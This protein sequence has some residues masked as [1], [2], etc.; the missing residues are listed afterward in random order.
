MQDAYNIEDLRRLARHRLP[1]GLFEFVDRGTED[2]VA[3]ANNRAAFERIKFAPHVLVDVS[4]RSQ[5]VELFGQ[6]YEMPLV[7]APT[8]SAGLMWHEGEIALA[9]AAAAAGIPCA[10]ATGS[11]TAME[12]VAEQGGAVWFQMAPW[13]DR[14]ITHKLVERAENAGYQALIVTVDGPVAANREYNL[15]N[16]Y[17]TPFSFTRRNTLDVLMH[18]RW[19][20]TV[21]GRYVATTGMPRYENYPSEV[22]QRITAQ[23]M[24]KARMV[25]DNAT[26]EDMR[27]LREKWRRPLIVKGITRAEDARTAVDYGA[28]GIIVSNH[29]G[30]VLDGV[31]APIAVLPEI[32]AAVGHRTTVMVDS[33]FRRGSDVVKAL[34]LGA[35]AVLIG[36]PTLYGT[37]VGG[38]AGAA[39]ALA[40]FRQEI[41]RVMAL[42]GAT[43]VSQLDQAFLRP[44]PGPHRFPGTYSPT[45]GERIEIESSEAKTG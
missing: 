23:P 26:W 21:L 6:R 19:L 8:G 35:K 17:T 38:E 45:I 13:P 24:G 43:A 10:L 4:R 29:G 14:S 41:D 30:R 36:R 33:G 15:R 16:G 20:L 1:R 5:A 42:I 18:P 25:T 11:M 3:I 9:R 31:E 44:Q 12:R 37:A 22:K 34:A 28:D 27:V 7:I 39:K 32:V 2:E 40:I